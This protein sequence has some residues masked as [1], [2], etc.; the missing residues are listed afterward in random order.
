MFIAEYL[1]RLRACPEQARGGLASGVLRSVR[2]YWHS[3]A[4]TPAGPR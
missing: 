4:R 1:V 2:A 3:I